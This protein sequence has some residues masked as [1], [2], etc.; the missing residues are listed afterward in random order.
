MDRMHVSRTGCWVTHVGEV[1]VLCGRIR[2]MLM[3]RL[4]E[5]FTGCYIPMSLLRLGIFVYV[6]CV[7]RNLDCSESQLMGMHHL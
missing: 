5:R 4:H 7:G 1:A 3:E 6:S 2:H